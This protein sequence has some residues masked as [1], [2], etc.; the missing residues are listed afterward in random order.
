MEVRAQRRIGGY[1]SLLIPSFRLSNRKGL[2]RDGRD[3]D[4][5]WSDDGGGSIQTKPL[6]IEPPI[7]SAA[8]LLE[9]AMMRLTSSA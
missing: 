9:P 4:C 6:R 2:C 5:V 8:F 1:A 7:G 3:G